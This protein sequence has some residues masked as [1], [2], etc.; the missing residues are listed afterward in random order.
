MDTLIVGLVVVVGVL[1][2]IGCIAGGYFIH[3]LQSTFCAHFMFNKNDIWIGIY[4][5]WKC[6]K[7]VYILPIPMIGVVITRRNK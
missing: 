5:A 4:N 6:K 1:Y 7:K 2:C 3:Y